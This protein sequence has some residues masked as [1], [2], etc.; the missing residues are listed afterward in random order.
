MLCLLVIQGQSGG[1]RVDLGLHDNVHIP[2]SLASMNDLPT[3]HKDDPYDVKEPKVVPFRLTIRGAT[4]NRQVLF[5]VVFTNC[6]TVTVTVTGLLL[7]DNY[8]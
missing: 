5:F 1:S 7:D 4:C 3:N 2:L 8:N 6:L